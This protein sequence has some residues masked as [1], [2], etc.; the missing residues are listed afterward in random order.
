VTAEEIALVVLI[1]LIGAAVGSFLNV[2]IHRLPRHD[3]VMHPPSQCPHCGRR[4]RWFEN[5]PIVSWVALRARCAGCKE[6]IS[7]MYPLVELLT[8]AVFVLAYL[9]F[10]TTPMFGVR[11]LFASAMIVLAVTDL[12]ERLLPNAITYPGVVIGLLCSLFL[13]PG[14]LSAVVGV[15]LGAG[16]PF[17]IGEAFYR[18][19][20]IEGLG[21]GDV[22]MLGMVG[23]FLG[24]QLALFTLFAASMLGVLIG[25]PLTVLKRDRYYQIPLGTFLALGA[26]VSAFVGDE[27]VQWYA[28]LYR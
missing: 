2:C 4:L 7:V 11:L 24:W 25:V 14:I 1:A 21:M 5:I 10:G 26:L 28:G 19:R 18:L 15:L 17:L 12:R 22:K 23:A 6:P 13:P 9:K 8:A 16:V 3:S 27:I 20:G